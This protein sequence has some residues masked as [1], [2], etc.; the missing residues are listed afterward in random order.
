M[1]QFEILQTMFSAMYEATLAVPSLI[2]LPPRAYDPLVAEL[3]AKGY[4]P[5]QRPGL[6]GFWEA[7][8]KLAIEFNTTDGST[9]RVEC[10]DA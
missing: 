1:S 3:K 10:G 2:V 5:L 8:Q 9:V 7:G 4:E 6:F